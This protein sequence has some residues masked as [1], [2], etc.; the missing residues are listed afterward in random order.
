MRNLADLREEAIEFL[1]LDTVEKGLFLFMHLSNRYL[2]LIEL[3]IFK[4]K[5]RNQICI[6]LNLSHHLAIQLASSAQ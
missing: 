1:N 3:Y 4:N 2:K 6:N 5:S